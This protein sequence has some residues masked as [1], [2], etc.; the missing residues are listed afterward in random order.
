MASFNPGSMALRSI[1]EVWN[2]NVRGNCFV[3]VRV[4]D[5]YPE[6]DGK[7]LAADSSVY[8]VSITIPSGSIVL[9]TGLLLDVV[10]NGKNFCA[11]GATQTSPEVTRE[12]VTLGPPTCLVV[13]AET[14]KKEGEDSLRSSARGQG[15]SILALKNKNSAAYIYLKYTMMSGRLDSSQYALLVETIEQNAHLYSNSELFFLENLNSD[16]AM[17]LKKLKRSDYFNKTPFDF[18]KLSKEEQDRVK[19]AAEGALATRG[20]ATEEGAAGVDTPAPDP[21]SASG[22]VQH[23]SRPLDPTMHMWELPS[24]K[25]KRGV[26]ALRTAL[27]EMVEE[28]GFSEEDVRPLGRKT[29]T[30]KVFIE[31]QQEGEYGSQKTPLVLVGY[32]SP[33]AIPSRRCDVYVGSAWVCVNHIVQDVTEAAAPVGDGGVRGSNFGSLVRV[34]NAE[35]WVEALD[36]DWEALSEWELEEAKKAM[37]NGGRD[38]GGGGDHSSSRGGG[39]GVGGYDSSSRGG[40]RGVGGYDS[41]SRGGGRGGGGYDSSS[42]GG[43]RGGGG[44]NSGGG[45]GGGSSSASSSGRPKL[46]LN[47]RTVPVDGAPSPNG[48]RQSSSIFGDG[49]ARDG[50][51]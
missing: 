31:D 35:E 38:R 15:F 8:G 51:V 6:E 18:T 28:T 10:L 44:Y 21:S 47:P 29:V 39:R 7:F 12:V 37:V 49:K 43:G 25:M 14:L 5:I 50:S 13:R 42:R 24:G 17:D 2:N 36:D 48:A 46:V 45:A 27:V 1:Q 20:H 40:G 33:T 16:E 34:G 23:I 22:S 32:T 41:S 26:S 3:R 11:I 30:K 19:S 4:I 9:R